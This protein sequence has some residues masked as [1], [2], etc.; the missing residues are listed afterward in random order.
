MNGAPH[1]YIICIN[2]DGQGTNGKGTAGDIIELQM[3]NIIATFGCDDILSVPLVLNDAP[4]DKVGSGHLINGSNAPYLHLIRGQEGKVNFDGRSKS[5]RKTIVK[6]CDTVK[7]LG[8]CQPITWRDLYEMPMTM[9]LSCGLWSEHNDMPIF[10]D[11]S[12]SMRRALLV[13]T[14]NKYFGTD[15]PWIKDDYIHRPEVRSWIAWYITTQLPCYE[16]YDSN[17]TK[18]LQEDTDD[19]LKESLNASRF[20]DEVLPNLPLDVIPAKLLFDIYS[21]WCEKNKVPVIYR[22]SMNSFYREMQQYPV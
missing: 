14:F 16:S 15:K 10:A 8:R 17:L 13:F 4:V 19:M 1:Y 7:N 18:L 5:N 22:M 12:A 20:F 11:N 21:V 3:V 2:G 6:D 9:A